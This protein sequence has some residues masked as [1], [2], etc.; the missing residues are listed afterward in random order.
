MAIFEVNILPK[1]IPRKIWWQLNSRLSSLCALTSHFESF[2]SIVQCGK[3]T[4]VT[5]VDKTSS[6][7]PSLSIN[8]SFRL[9]RAV[10]IFRTML[11]GK[12]NRNA[13]EACR[14]FTNELSQG[15]FF[16]S[17]K[18]FVKTLAWKSQCGNSRI[19]LSLRFYVKS[20]FVKSRESK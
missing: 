15:L 18:F 7:H 14:H 3:I 13:N 1:L 19:F 9:A 17:W 16:F 20:I 5:K 11:D 6:F 4:T 2:W 10:C 8:V 12:L